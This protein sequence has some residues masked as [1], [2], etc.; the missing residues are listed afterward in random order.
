MGK[1]IISTPTRKP[2]D[3]N[4]YDNIDERPL[5][6]HRIFGEINNI[7]GTDIEQVSHS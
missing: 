2:R 5:I 6:K 3:L 4:N 7:A 1:I